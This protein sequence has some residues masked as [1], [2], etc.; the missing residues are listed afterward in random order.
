L[1]SVRGFVAGLA[2]AAVLVAM[3]RPAAADQLSDYQAQEAQIESA[4]ASAQARYAAA[5]AQYAQARDQ[6]ARIEGAVAAVNAEIAKLD[7]QV[8]AARAR[9]DDLRARIAATEQ[10]LAQDRQRSDEGL[11][12]L[13][14]RGTTSFLAVVLGAQ[15]FSDFLTRLEFLAR[16]WANEIGLLKQTQTAEARLQGQQAALAATIREL[17]N[18][19]AQAATQRAALQAQQQAADAARLREAEAQAEAADAIRSLTQQKNGIVAAINA[20]LA[21]MRAGRVSWSQVMAIVD[22]LAR[23]YG[24][25]PK[26]V[27]AVIIAESGGD[28]TA[29]S[30]VGA[31]GLMQLMPGTAA[32]LGVTD[33]YDPVQNVKGGI[34][35]LLQMLQLF[36]GDLK[37]AIAAYNAGPGAV[38]KY[39]GIP[40][41]AETQNYVNEVLGLYQQGK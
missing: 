3:A 41:Y 22:Q 4:L 6:L 24:I 11:V 30:S 10:Q 38:E 1:A 7:G 37:L 20:L 25:D 9:S 34:T 2:V 14:Q 26:L 17:Q 13:Q 8:A 23:Q 28:A 33:P 16:I 15:S 29:T 32:G 36:H 5:Q 40:P 35:Y 27:E 18:S 39:G 31:E 19:R 12:L 21:Q